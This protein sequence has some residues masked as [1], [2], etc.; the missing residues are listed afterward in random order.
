MGIHM[1]WGRRVGL[2]E[3]VSVILDNGCSEG[4]DDMLLRGLSESL[5]FLLERKAFSLFSSETRFGVR[6]W[7]RRWDDLLS[8]KESNFMSSA[9]AGCFFKRPRNTLVRSWSSISKSLFSSSSSESSFSIL[10]FLRGWSSN[11]RDRRWCVTWKSSFGSVLRSGKLFMFKKA[12]DLEGEPVHEIEGF[13][14]GEAWME[15]S[16]KSFIWRSSSLRMFEVSNE[17]LASLF[18]NWHK[19]VAKMKLSS[20]PKQE[21]WRR[22]S[23]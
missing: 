10:S 23:K 12:G 8:R 22:G 5:G 14:T 6:C 4:I 7:G 11:S 15:I 2:L 1:R 20:R 21:R 9:S 3:L 16:V 18:M 13:F 19:S 17:A